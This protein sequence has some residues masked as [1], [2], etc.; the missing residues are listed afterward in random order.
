MLSH[1]LAQALLA[2]RNN[3]IQFVVEVAE[4]GH[5][6]GDFHTTEMNDDRER[7]RSGGTD[8]DVIGYDAENDFIIIKLGT[9]FLGDP[10]APAK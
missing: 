10:D 3:D 8:L 1:D 5:D 7:V 6:D 9:I 4:E 2:R